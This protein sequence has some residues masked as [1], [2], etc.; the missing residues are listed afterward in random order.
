[1]DKLKGTLQKNGNLQ[2]NLNL[3]KNVGTDDYNRLYN[4]PSI[5]SVELVGD[6]SA[7]DIGLLT[8]ADIPPIPEHIIDEI[9]FGGG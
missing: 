2:G 7:A 3:A 4:K 1:M 8:D 5:E 6:L 9:I